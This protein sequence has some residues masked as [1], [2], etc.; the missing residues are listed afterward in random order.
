MLLLELE[1]AEA[2][3]EVVVMGSEV[4]EGL[5]E[6]PDDA[7]CVSDQVVDLGLELGDNLGI[8]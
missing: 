2:V 7:V 1:G 3:L 6:V 4:V 5:L 8:G